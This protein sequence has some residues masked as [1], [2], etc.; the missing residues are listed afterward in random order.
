M[1][2]S[3]FYW[4]FSLFFYLS[5]LAASEITLLPNYDLNQYRIEIA[6]I[7]Q[8]KFFVN[9][10]LNGR[11]TF[12]SHYFLNRRYQ[13]GALGEGANAIF[14]QGPL[15]RTDAFDCVTLVN[16][17]LAISLANNVP[18]FT[19]MIK[20]MQYKNGEVNYFNRLHFT[21][22][23]WNQAHAWLRDITPKI[24][25]QFAIAEAIIDKPE[26]YRHKQSASL[27]RCSLLSAPATQQ[28]LVQLQQH[29]NSEAVYLAKTTYIPLQALFENSLAVRSAILNAIPSGSIIEIVNKT[30][31]FKGVIGTD[32]N[33]AHLGFAIREQG[34]LWFC[35]AS[36]NC[37]RV[38]IVSLAKYLQETYARTSRPDLVGVHVMA[39]D[40]MCGNP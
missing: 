30:K 20:K 2:K 34:Q 40:S 1:I 26:W 29:G 10:D 39:I 35:H 21:E 9:A 37:G 23:D 32:L 28:L 36:K 16:T 25:A 6:S 4:I 33:I 22:L 24:F 31:D 11:I 15:Y 12:L 7:Y 13:L 14:D 8:N 17:I 3:K 19:Q 38:I 27:K 5:S 18:E